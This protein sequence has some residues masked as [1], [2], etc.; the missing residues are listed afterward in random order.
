MYN[1]RYKFSQGVFK[2]RLNNILVLVKFLNKCCI[3][4][5][6]KKKKLKF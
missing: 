2:E 5:I 6:M 1:I 3:R 4:R